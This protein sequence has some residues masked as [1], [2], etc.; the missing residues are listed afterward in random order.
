MKPL[1]G[2]KVVA[3]VMRVGVAAVDGY[4]GD[5]YGGGA[6]TSGGG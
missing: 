3:A 5:D 4:G 1:V 2:G 6:E